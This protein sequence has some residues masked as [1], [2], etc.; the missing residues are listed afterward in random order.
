MFE[1]LLKEY[2][3]YLRVTKNLSKN[4]IASYHNDLTDY[5]GFLDKNYHIN[6]PDKVEKQHV[7]NYL[8]RLKRAELS[9]KSISRKISS[10]KSFHQY[11]RTEKLVDDNVVET[12]PLPKTAKQLPVV[13]NLEEIETLLETSKGAGTI[14]D[15]RNNAMIELAYG[16]GLR[17]SELIG[18]NVSDLHL[19]MGFVKIFGKGSKERIVPLGENSVIALRRYLTDARPLIHPTQKEILFPN[20]DGNRL[21]RIGFYKIIQSLAQ[22]AGIEKP[23]SPHTLRHSFAT[24]L[25]ENGADLRAVQELLG[26]EDVMTTENYTHISKHHL[27]EAY[28]AAHPR[29]S[30]KK[31]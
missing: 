14:L 21:S 2:V 16:S 13:L 17:V 5:V 24:H 20:K 6:R 28:E 10:L 4:T 11:L 1:S 7:L 23:I 12:V 31:E 3:Y 19:N 27:Q 22:K 15:W 26:H 30:G 8:A 29:A 18:L 9:P 25:L